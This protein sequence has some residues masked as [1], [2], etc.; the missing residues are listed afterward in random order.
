MPWML[1]VKFD[2]RRRWWQVF[3]IRRIENDY[4]FVD[5]IAFYYII[6]LIQRR[7]TNLGQITVIVTVIVKINF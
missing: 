7:G 5:C 3:V 4:T 1:F 6:V 2:R